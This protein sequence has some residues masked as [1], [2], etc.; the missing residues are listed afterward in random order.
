ML[1][2]QLDAVPVP[3]SVHVAP[4][5]VNVPVGVLLVPVSVSVT[6]TLHE[7]CVPTVPDD[8]QET[9]VLVVRALTVTEKTVLGPLPV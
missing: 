4:L 7:N 5:T 9:F 1:M 8:G 3:A 6:V 2:V